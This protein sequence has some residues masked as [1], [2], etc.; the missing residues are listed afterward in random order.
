[1]FGGSVV[2]TERTDGIWSVSVCRQHAGAF[3]ALEASAGSVLQFESEPSLWYFPNTRKQ[4][5]KKYWRSCLLSVW[6]KKKLDRLHVHLR[7][8]DA[9]S[10]RHVRLFG[11][12][13][14]RTYAL[15][16][17]SCCHDLFKQNDL[18]VLHC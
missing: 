5:L 17:T 11:Y 16:C 7:Y 14:T 3:M 15:V 10:M 6:K 12:N 4:I 2:T 18:F 1:M 8:C 9:I 13:V